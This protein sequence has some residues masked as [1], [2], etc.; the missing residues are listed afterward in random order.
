MSL[1]E[2]EDITVKSVLDMEEERSNYIFVS[3]NISVAE[4]KQKFANQELLEVVLITE[5]GK[6]NEQLMGIV[7]RWDILRI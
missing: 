5:K 2:L 1:V 4:V 6:K 3:R 7:T